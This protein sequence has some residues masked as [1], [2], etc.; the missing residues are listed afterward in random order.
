ML[1]SGDLALA[2]Q[3]RMPMAL[4]PPRRGNARSIFG[5]SLPLRLS[6][7]GLGA[8]A[9]SRH[10]MRLSLSY[11]AML[12]HRPPNRCP[13]HRRA[14]QGPTFPPRYPTASTSTGKR[15]RAIHSPPCTKGF[16]N[17]PLTEPTL[18]LSRPAQH[19]LSG[20]VPATP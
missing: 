10:E 16:N 13:R 9:A 3:E 2:P 15:L 20:Q 6:T 14:A 1:G 4:S 12:L 19:G 17:Q 18:R 8:V 11:A 7:S 5:I